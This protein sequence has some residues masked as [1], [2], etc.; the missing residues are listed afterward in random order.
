MDGNQ[1]KSIDSIVLKTFT[2]LYLAKTQLK[3]FNLSTLN[4]KTITH[5]D[6]SYNNILIDKMIYLNELQ[7]LDLENVHFINQNHSFE[8]FFGPNLKNID[9]SNNNLSESHFAA[10]SCLIKLEIIELRNVGLQS[11]TQ[12]EF[13]NLSNLTKMAS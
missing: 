7:I 10:L 5:L 6:L 2:S 11:M 9:L 8:L 3:Y 1:V 4:W 12:I 13:N